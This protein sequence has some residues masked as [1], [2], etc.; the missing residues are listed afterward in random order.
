MYRAWGLRIC[1]E[2][3]CLCVC[4]CVCVGGGSKGLPLLLPDAHRRCAWK[5][6]CFRRQLWRT[7][8]Y[9]IQRQGHVIHNVSL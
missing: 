9:C 2:R 8:L 7:V 1:C 3:V 4:L 6:T 5:R